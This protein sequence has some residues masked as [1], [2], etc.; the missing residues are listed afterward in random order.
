MTFSRLPPKELA[1]FVSSVFQL[2]ERRLRGSVSFVCAHAH[3]LIFI[4]RVYACRTRKRV[5]SDADATVTASEPSTKRSQRALTAVHDN[6]DDDEKE[7]G[8]QQQS[9]L[10]P[11]EVPIDIKFPRAVRHSLGITTVLSLGH[12][13][14]G[15]AWEV[16][17]AIH[18]IRVFVGYQARWKPSSSSSSSSP[19]TPPAEWHLSV[20]ETAPQWM[21]GL[22][23]CS[24]SAIFF[25][26]CS[27]FLID[28]QPDDEKIVSIR[29]CVA[30]CD[31]CAA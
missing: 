1:P 7:D 10:E 14:S 15:M 29:H 20:R 31:T 5:V 26:M 11:F 25:L 2:L 22:L 4:T 12:E 13:A 18:K 17:I 19:T 21:V 28:A 27:F 30:S 6:D 24:V 3:V 9:V 8:E 16:M 23:V